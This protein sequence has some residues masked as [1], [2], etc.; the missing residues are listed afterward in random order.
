M[1][2]YGCIVCGTELEYLEHDINMC[3]SVCGKTFQTN[4]RC[5]NKHFVCDDCHQAEGADYI[6]TYCLSSTETNPVILINT[7]MK[8]PKIKMH[9]PEH[10]FLVPAVLL[11]VFYNAAGDHAVLGGKLAVARKR[12]QVIPGGFC[13]FYG[14][15]GAGVGTGIFMSIIT[16]AT[17]LSTDA[18]RLSNLM[19]ARSLENIACHGGPRCCKRDSFLALESAVQFFR[20]NMGVNLPMDTI[21]CGFSAKNRDCKKQDC[22]FFDFK[23]VRLSHS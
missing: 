4:V 12:A 19:T 22:V 6:E 18:W 8:N 9:G 3:C 21:V 15:C 10:H 1:F 2:D 11:T 23:K 20:E 14:N 16:D 13:G 17:P 5:R 7:I